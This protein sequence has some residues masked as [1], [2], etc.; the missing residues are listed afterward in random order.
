LHFMPGINISEPEFI[1]FIKDHP[2]FKGKDDLSLSRL[3]QYKLNEKKAVHKNN[4]GDQLSFLKQ[5]NIKVYIEYDVDK[6]LDRA[7]ELINRTNQL[8]FT[9]KRLSEDIDVA[10]KELQAELS[11]NT[12]NAGLIR[13]VDNY[14]DY[15]FIGFYLIKRTLNKNKL[16]HFCFSCRTLNMYI[17]H[18]LYNYLEKPELTIVGEVISDIKKYNGDIDWI[19]IDDSGDSNPPFP[20]VSSQ[21]KFHRIYA[22]GG[23]DMA[24]LIHYFTSYSKNIVTEFNVVRNGQPIRLDHSSFLIYSLT[25]DIRDEKLEVASRLGYEKSDFQSDF[26]SDA[27]ENNLYLL[28]FWADA[29]IPIYRHKYSDLRLPYW[30]IGA[31]DKD[32]TSNESLRIKLPKNSEQIMQLDYL[33]ENFIYEGILSC[34]EMV[35]RYI[36]I[37]SSIK[38]S[39]KIILILANERGLLSFANSSEQNN[40]RHKKL[41]NALRKASKGYSNVLLIDPAKVINTANDI[42]DLNHFKREVYYKLFRIIAE[43]LNDIQV[44]N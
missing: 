31:L 42:F 23:C 35:A 7:I 18:W 13:V 19:S 43:K 41:N 27:A 10:R 29:D 15:G 38:S 34:E 8:N 2:K 32:L 39:S 36:K 11:H 37:I 21:K 20:D 26:R 22:R 6:Y 4:I 1:P 28:S 16:I 24:S 17:E 14:G 44:A 25:E 40:P 5:S 3:S 33:H 9:K 12:C 30:L